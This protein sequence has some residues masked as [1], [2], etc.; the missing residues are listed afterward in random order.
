MQKTFEAERCDV[1]RQTMLCSTLRLK[2]PDHTKIINIRCYV[3]ISTWN[4]YKY[5]CT[6]YW[7]VENNNSRT[8]AVRLT[9][10]TPLERSEGTPPCCM[11]LVGLTP[12][13]PQ[14]EGRYFLQSLYGD[15]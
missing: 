3:L 7:P 14:L 1:E 15:T 11:I 4:L 12:V 8:R 13:H 6:W 2:Y 9:S 10:D 5:T